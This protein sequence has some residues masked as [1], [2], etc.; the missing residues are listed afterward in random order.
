MKL[1]EFYPHI[2]DAANAIVPYYDPMLLKAGEGFNLD[3]PETYLL[4]ALPSFKD[5]PISIEL[6]NVRSPYTNEEIYRKRLESMTR[7][8]ILDALD[9]DHFTLTERGKRAFEIL[10]NAAYS[11][12]SSVAPLPA[13]DL[14]K[15]AD[16]LIKRVN[17]CLAAPEPPGKW[18]IQ[19]S[20]ELDPGP[21]AAVMVR[22]DQYLSDV[23]AYRDD[24]HLAAWKPTGVD[25]HT[26]DVLTLLWLNGSESIDTA[27]QKLVR[28]GHPFEKPEEAFKTLVNLHWANYSLDFYT[29]TQEGREARQKAEELTDTYFYAPWKDASS[30]ELDTLADLLLRF[31]QGLNS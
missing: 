26:W 27:M 24:A 19:H 28:R 3:G 14:A 5:S 8:G 23:I 6:L 30:R 9:E 20:H 31:K 25:G 17:S 1:N 10:R 12:M 21:A 2:L 16:L 18:C 29:I 4:L 7:V 22:L 15:L 13:K 11:G